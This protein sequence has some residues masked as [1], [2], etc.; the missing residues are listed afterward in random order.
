VKSRAVIVAVGARTPIGLDATSSAFLYRAS[1]MV[2]QH[3]PLL[4]PER[5]PVNLCAL[6]TLDPLSTGVPRAIDLASPA[7]D[8]AVAALGGVE[9]RLRVRLVLAIDETFGGHT[10]SELA[11]ALGRRVAG[12]FA[13]SSI[14]VTARGAAGLGFAL[15]EPLRQLES[16]ALDAL[17]VG[18]VHTDYDPAAI[19]ALADAGRLFRVDRPVAVL[20]GESAAFAVLMRPAVARSHGLAPSTQLHALATA[21]DRA[22]PD[23]DEPAFVASGTTSAL[24]RVAEPLGDDG[25]RAGW[26]LTDLGFEPQRLYELQAAT[27]RNRRFLC[28]PHQV[29]APAQRLGNLGAAALP[30]FLVLAAEAHRRGWAPHAIAVAMA[31]S[32]GGERAALLL[33]AA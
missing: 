17:V 4:D 8:E 22:R 1:N 2:M 32:D 25:L 33:S 30:F 14:A 9:S 7:L 31:G 15:D 5:E 23:N 3:G 28:E 12:R 29:D 24:R 19:A 16:G 21:V 18:G 11:A 20:P 6:Q 26:L 27:L 10:G 13:E